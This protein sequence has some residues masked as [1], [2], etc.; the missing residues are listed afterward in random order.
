MYKLSMLAGLGLLLLAI[1]LYYSGQV[2]T[3]YTFS[4]VLL[5]AILLIIGILGDK[6]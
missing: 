3:M 5:G 1:V 6:P 4:A 2:W